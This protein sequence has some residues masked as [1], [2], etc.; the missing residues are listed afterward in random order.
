VRCVRHAMD[1]CDCGP[2]DRTLEI[3]V[4]DEHLRDM[5][6]ALLLG[7]DDEDADE[8]N[9]RS[10]SPAAKRAKPTAVR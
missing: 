8:S 4:S 1:A 3:R 9:A 10:D 5:S 2:D 6:R 7:R